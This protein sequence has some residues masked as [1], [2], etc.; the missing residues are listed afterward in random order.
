VTELLHV[1]AAYSHDLRTPLT[2]M[3]DRVKLHE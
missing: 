3:V 1:L 2:R